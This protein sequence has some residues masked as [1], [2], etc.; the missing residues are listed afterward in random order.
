MGLT[1][2]ILENSSVDTIGSRIENSLIGKN[3]MVRKTDKKPRA[4]RLMLG[5][6][7]EV[8]LL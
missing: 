4:Y 8:G 3:V 6:N 2:I 7:S 5:D 1:S